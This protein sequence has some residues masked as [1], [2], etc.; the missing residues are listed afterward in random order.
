ML[1]SNHKTIVINEKREGKLGGDEYIHS[2]DCGGD[3]ADIYLSNS[4]SCIC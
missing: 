2:I 1:C 3:L 4:P